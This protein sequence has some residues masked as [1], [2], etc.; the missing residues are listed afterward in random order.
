MPKPKIT[1]ETVLH[2]NGGGRYST[3]VQKVL[4]D[5]EE[6]KITLGTHTDGSP[7]F[8]VTGRRLAY[9][10]PGTWSEEDRETL[11]LLELGGKQE[12]IDAWILERR[13]E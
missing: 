9:Q 2:V 6:T 12:V 11:D 7:D 13:P 5:G 4:I 1:A 8:N 3:L 10:P